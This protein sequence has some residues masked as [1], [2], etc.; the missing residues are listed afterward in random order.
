MVKEIIT[1]Y[2]GFTTK[3]DYVVTNVLDKV[4]VANKLTENVVTGVYQMVQVQ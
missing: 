3:E 4:D 2:N 1:E